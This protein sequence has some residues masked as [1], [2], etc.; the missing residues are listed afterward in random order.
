MS[1]KP[2]VWDL[3]TRL[4]H[5]LLVILVTASLV[6]NQLEEI[7]WHYYSGLGVLGL[8]IFR[9][10]WGFVGSYYS[11]FTTF[12][13]GPITILQYLKGQFAHKVG[14]NPLGALSVIVMLLSLLTQAIT[15]LFMTDEVIFDGP[16]FPAIDEE[17]AG[18]VGLVHEI[19]SYVIYGLI[20]LHV[21]AIGFYQLVKKQALIGAMVKGVS[22]A[23]ELEGAAYMKPVWLAVVVLI[24]SVGVVAGVVWFAPEPVSLGF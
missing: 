23:H 1:E 22:T 11:R 18:Y 17:V 24:V 20:G 4:F 19:N 3:A 16:W 9:I 14:H 7:D 6:T 12:I 13:R 5:W 21:L 10:I 2:I 8:L 15:G